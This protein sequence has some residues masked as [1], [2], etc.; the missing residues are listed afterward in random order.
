MVGQDAYSASKANFELVV[1]SN[2]STFYHQC[3]T[4]LKATTRAGKKIGVG[5]LSENTLLP[6]LVCSKEQRQ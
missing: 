2:C 5:D 3:D 1:G 4:P 6:D